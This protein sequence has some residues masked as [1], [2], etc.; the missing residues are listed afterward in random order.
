MVKSL[1]KINSNKSKYARYGVNRELKTIESDEIDSSEDIE[2]DSFNEND[3]FSDEDSP[4]EFDDS[5]E[6]ELPVS[7]HLRSKGLFKNVWWKKGLLKGFV[8]WLSI[9]IIFYIFDFIGLVE[10]IDW[11]KWL[12][13]LIFLMLV[14][15]AYEKFF[16]N[17]I[18]K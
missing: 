16:Y 6:N 13:F 9:V 12:F 1:K 18:K 4:S 2:D 8:I 11:K 3:E 17:K 14:G 5:N 10:V 15:M 7:N